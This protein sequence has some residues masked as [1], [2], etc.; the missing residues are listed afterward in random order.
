MTKLHFNSHSITFTES[1]IEP[2]RSME[3]GPTVYPINLIDLLCV[4]IP[5]CVDE[6]GWISDEPTDHGEGLGFTIDGDLNLEK[7]ARFLTPI[8]IPT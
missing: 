3:N 5:L 1:D 6:T 2:P 8:I 7:L 4:E